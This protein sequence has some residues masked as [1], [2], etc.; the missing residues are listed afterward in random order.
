M[1]KTIALFTLVLLIFTGN[2]Q[3]ITGKWNGL[4]KIPGMELRLTI[5]IA[6]NDSGYTSTL[7]SP[8][9]QVKGIAIA[10]TSFENPKLLLKITTPEIQYAGELKGELIEGIFK[11]AGQSIPLT[12]TRKEIEKKPLNRP[13]EPI[14]PY[15]YYTEEVSIQNTNAGVSLAGTLSLPKKEG[16]FPAVI[17]IT[18]S[19]PQN[20]DEELLGHKP[21]LVIAD[22]LTKKGIAV[23]RCDDRGFGKSTGDFKSATSADFATD[24]VSAIDYLKTREDIEKDKI[25]LIGHSEGGLIA[26]IAATHSKD[27][28]FIVLLAGTGIRGDKLSLLQQALVARAAGTAKSEIR[29]T[30]AILS[31]AYNIILQSTDTVQM[32]RELTAYGRKVYQ[33]IPAKDKPAETTEDEF[34]HSKVSELTTPWMLYFLRFDP[35]ETLARVTCPVLALNGE[36]DL[37]VPPK[38]NLTAI[39]N[40]LKKGGNT[41]IDIELLPNLNHLF[42]ECTTGSPAE[43]TSIEQTF[44]PK[45]LE[46]MARWI[47]THT[48]K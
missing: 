24:I 48:T 5:N 46:L 38:E 21:F 22:Y 18:G 29:N 40:A 9:Q 14:Q 37:Q 20:R 39:K 34:V 28:S 6:K 26:P 17:L 31:T 16:K 12:L 7:D 13:Q 10:N 25:G 36:K 30:Q 19:G 4:L 44:S 33:A 32:I 27:V 23:L 41:D 47:L 42:Q 35:A 1:K 15:P 11:Q 43:Y 2:G 45:V 3:N 8:D